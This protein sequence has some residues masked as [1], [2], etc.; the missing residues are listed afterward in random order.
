MPTIAYFY[1]IAIRMFFNDHPPPHFHARYAGRE[2][3]IEEAA[4]DA[5][6]AG[7]AAVWVDE[8]VL[9]SVLLCGWPRALTGARI[10]RQEGFPVDPGSEDGTDY[11]EYGRWKARGEATCRTVYGETYAALR[12]NIH[13]LHP[14]LEAGM[15]VEGYGRILGRP[16]LDLARRELCT[17]AQIAVQGARRQ[18]RAHLQGALNAGASAAAVQEALELAR[19][20]MDPP[21]WNDALLLWNRVRP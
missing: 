14:A 9:Q 3:R 18:L 16:E 21:G 15:I 8:L 4:R 10:C 6:S 2:A 7:V 11:G 12:R 20:L 13:A 17:I 19:P 1:G 5:R